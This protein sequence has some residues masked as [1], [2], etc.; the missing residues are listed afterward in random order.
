MLVVPVLPSVRLASVIEMLGS[1]LCRLDDDAAL[2]TRPDAAKLR[3]S[4]K[5]RIAMLVRL[6]R[7]VT[8][9]E[10]DAAAVA[11]AATGTGAAAV[12]VG[13]TLMTAASATGGTDDTVGTPAATAM[14]NCLLSADRLAAAGIAALSAGAETSDGTGRRMAA[15][16]DLLNPVTSVTAV[17]DAC[18]LDDRWVLAAG[19]SAGDGEAAGWG[20]AGSRRETTEPEECDVLATEVVSGPV[21]SARAMPAVLR[22]I[23]TPMPS[24]AAK[25]QTR[26]MACLAGR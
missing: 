14:V 23:P 11:L 10:D 3:E 1:T 18:D 12:T 17:A 7:A 5:F 26:P 15:V 6:I 13:L 25:P 2:D 24:A 21:E 19:R 22:L 8:R 4:I 9:V 20:S 16:L